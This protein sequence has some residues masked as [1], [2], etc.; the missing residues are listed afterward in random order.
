MDPEIGVGPT[1]APPCDFDQGEKPMNTATHLRAGILL[2]LATTLVF[3]A[4]G[5][6]TGPVDPDAA[7]PTTQA[8]QASARPLAVMTRNLYLGGDT[9]PL[10]TLDFSDLPAVLAATNGF[11]ADV[12]ASDFAGR[13]SSLAEEIVR[14]RPGVVG[15]QEGVLLEVLDGAF[16]PI[17]EL[18]LLALLVLELE[19]RGAGYEVVAVRENTS[20]ALP[21]GVSEAGVDR[22]L[23][24]TDRIAMLVRTDVPVLGEPES[25]NYAATFTVGP[26]E[27]PVEL[28]RGWIRTTVMA[29]GA[30][31]TVVNT[32]LEIQAL[33][34]VQAGQAQELIA[35]LLP[36]DQNV[37]LLGDLNSDAE[38]GPGAPSWTPTYQALLDTG[39]V[40]G[41]ERS[42]VSGRDPG[43][44]CCH[45]PDL[46]NEVVS[47]D[48]RIDF[49]LVR[50]VQ[51]VGGPGVIPGSI[52]MA[53]LGDELGDRTDGGLWPSDHGGLVARI[54]LA[55]PVLA[56]P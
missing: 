18:D 4:C 1:S 17:A 42:D 29:G 16:T 32:H 11:L 41:W 56:R 6:V 55:R 38:A 24:F 48:Q 51:G 37:V 5:D 40:D 9:G 28:K 47:F 45:D 7:P 21:L 53:I 3:A 13:A 36:D 50:P 49:V 35:T 44:T 52:R 22:W 23:R 12:Q 15:L 14:H 25:G 19:S 34:P 26:P 30:P 33:A 43:F 10:L 8:F 20:S 2:A 54:R 46:R 27:A 31:W 39:F